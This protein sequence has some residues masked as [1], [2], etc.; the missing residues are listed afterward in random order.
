MDA[1]PHEEGGMT[2][3]VLRFAGWSGE[4]RQVGHRGWQRPDA[5]AAACL[6]ASGRAAPIAPEVADQTEDRQ[7]AIEALRAEI[8]A[9]IGADLRTEITQQMALETEAARVRAIKEGHE[10]GVKQGLAQAQSRMQ[11]EI[12]RLAA[13][14]DQLG[15]Q[16]D[17]TLDGIE[18]LVFE[19]VLSACRRIL[20]DAA[21]SGE[22]ARSVV[23]QVLRE[24]RREQIL[25]VRVHPADRDGLRDDRSGK[26]EG[27]PWVSDEGVQ[28]GGCLVR[29]AGGTIEARLDEQLRLLAKVL[30]DGMA[31]DA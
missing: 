24:V 26:L 27:L 25:E 19:L 2:T 7:A 9:D 6:T 17:A 20:G 15:K 18:G 11:G 16:V 31:L 28:R 10:L 4:T 21:L 5:L 8:K 12:D 13:L 23:A 1:S 14:G 22:A 30:A 29:F 3:T